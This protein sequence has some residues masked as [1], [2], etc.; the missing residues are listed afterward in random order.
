[1]SHA[2]RKVAKIEAEAK[3]KRIEAAKKQAEAAKKVKRDAEMAVARE[4]AKIRQ[5][6][7]A[8]AMAAWKADP[9]NNP[10]PGFWTPERAG[11]AVLGGIVGLL[12]VAISV[13]LVVQHNNDQK[14]ALRASSTFTTSAASSSSNS[15][16]NTDAAI[17]LVAISDGIDPT[18]AVSLVHQVCD[19]LDS[20]APMAQVLNTAL[21]HGDPKTSGTILGMAF[22]SSKAGACPEYNAEYLRTVKALGY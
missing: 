6:Q 21:S 9:A 12:A 2:A 10:K 8:A 1:M 3:L 19:A 4:K 5:A 20:G 17:R 18:Q 11:L 16:S 15:R 7:R 13:G 14:K 22:G